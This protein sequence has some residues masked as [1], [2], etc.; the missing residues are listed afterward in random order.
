[1]LELWSNSIRERDGLQRIYLFDNGLGR[2]GQLGVRWCRPAGLVTCTPSH[3]SQHFISPHPS[4]NH[5]QSGYSDTKF[6]S[7][8]GSLLCFLLILLSTFLRHTKT[9]GWRLWRTSGDGICRG[10][11]AW[12]ALRWNRCERSVSSEQSW[13]VGAAECSPEQG[14]GMSLIQETK[15]L[16]YH[17]LPQEILMQSIS[18]QHTH[19]LTHSVNEIIFD[20]HELL[21]V[22]GSDFRFY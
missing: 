21:L 5:I 12:F 6:P 10:A 20:S 11:V 17:R 13:V 9:E 4:I 19:T 22:L 7:S 1:M 2:S 3:I 15:T 16:L 8:I 14:R 18:S